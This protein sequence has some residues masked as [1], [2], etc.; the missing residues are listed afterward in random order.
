MGGESIAVGGKYFRGSGA[1]PVPSPLGG[2]GPPEGRCCAG[3]LLPSQM[4]EGLGSDPP[5]ERRVA[6]DRPGAGPSV[7]FH[8]HP[9][10]TTLAPWAG[11]WISRLQARRPRYKPRQPR[12]W[13]R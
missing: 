2:E 13:R 3:G 5:L 6:G 9:E 11:T 8:E 1:S 4:W 12:R 7:I 10:T